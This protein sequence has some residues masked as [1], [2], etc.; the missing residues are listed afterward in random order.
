[1]AWSRSKLFGSN[2][3]KRGHSALGLSEL[4]EAI[5][6]PRLPST[7]KLRS[8]SR[9]VCPYSVAAQLMELTRTRRLDEFGN[10][11]KWC[12]SPLR[13]FSRSDWEPKALGQPCRMQIPLSSMCADG[14]LLRNASKVGG[15]RLCFDNETNPFWGAIT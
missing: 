10:Q 6:K 1:M 5:S 7:L 8:C 4:A 13:I 3:P 14:K 11:T 9:H 2:I 15:T 12:V